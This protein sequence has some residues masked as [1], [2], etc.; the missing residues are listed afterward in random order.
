MAEKPENESERANWKPIRLKC[1]T[2]GHR[3]PGRSKL[4][5]DTVQN[6]KDI[7]RVGAT[8]SDAARAFKVSRSTVKR[9]R[10]DG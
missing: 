9:I 2:C 7:I 6:I 1:P 4:A 8:I 10:D 5:P 3:R